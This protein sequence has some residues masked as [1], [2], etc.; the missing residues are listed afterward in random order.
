MVTFKYLWYRNRKNIAGATKPTYRVTTK[1]R[2]AKITTS[3][4]RYIA[5]AK[6]SAAKTVH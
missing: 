4:S 2:R 5:V 1:D 6:S 3:Q